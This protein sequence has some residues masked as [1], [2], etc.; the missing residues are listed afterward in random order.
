MEFENMLTTDKKTP[1]HIRARQQLLSRIAELSAKGI[2]RLPPERALYAEFGVNLNTVQKAINQLTHEGRLVSVP[3][4]GRFIQTLKA[5]KKNIGIVIGG[6]SAVTFIRDPEMLGHIFDVLTNR[7]CFVRLIQLRNPE[8]APEVF[9]HYKIDGCI[10]YQPH[11]PLFPKISKLMESCKIPMVVPL[12][13][14]S[15]ADATKLPQNHFAIDFSGI[16]RVRAEYLIKRGHRNIVYCGDRESGTYDAFVAALEK[17]GI[18]QNPDWY[19]SKTEEIPERLPGILDSGEFT[20]IISDGGAER[21]EPVF[22]I[23]DSH[24]WSRKGDFLV[25]SIGEKLSELRKSYPR[26]KVTAVNFSPHHEIAIGA[27][28][29]L[30]D[31]VKNGKPIQSA[32]FVSQVKAL[33]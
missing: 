26:V 19:I 12:V 32:K 11:P 30:V 18:T 17:G 9:R 3:R 22:R 20:A 15:P 7:G 31:A 8:E 4:K 10:W 24:P 29:A 27:A 1:P 33:D 21:L 28:E 23:L 2:N 13:T 5:E 14:V 16:G 25:D 6:R